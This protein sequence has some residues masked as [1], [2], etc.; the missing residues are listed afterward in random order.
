MIRGALPVAGSPLELCE[1]EVN[2]CHEWAR[3][4][5]RREG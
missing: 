1:P 4:D 5:L 2:L 3:T